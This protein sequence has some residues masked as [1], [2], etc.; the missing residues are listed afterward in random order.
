MK[1]SMFD[2]YP[3]DQKLKTILIISIILFIITCISVNFA[4]EASGYP[5]SFMESQ[6]SFSGEVIK[7][8][9]SVMTDTQIQQYF[10]AQLVDYTFIFSFTLLIFS[11]GIYLGRKLPKASTL[12]KSAYVI[13]LAGIIAG[14]CDSIENGFILLMIKDH[15]TFP[16]IYAIIH[17]CFASVKYSLLGLSIIAI[18]SLLLVYIIKYKPMKKNAS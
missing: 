14:C 11:T 15:A 4:F 10:Y 7:S 6:L 9:Y 13:A 18:V 3:H 1:L 5:V 12:R 17:S 16:N 8:H 2:T